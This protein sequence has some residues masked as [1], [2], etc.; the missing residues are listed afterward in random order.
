MAVPNTFEGYRALRDAELH[1]D[2]YDEDREDC[3]DCR[4]PAERLTLDGYCDP[5]LQYQ[6]GYDQAQET[7]AVSLLGG[8]IM[9]ALEADI[10]REL[11]RKTIDDA[12]EASDDEV[13]SFMEAGAR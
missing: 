2:L 10:P 13:R 8:A 6:W 4:K 3:T 5:C 1:P 11:I 7:T 12:F 9:A